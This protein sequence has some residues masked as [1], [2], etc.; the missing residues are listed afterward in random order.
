[1]NFSFRYSDHAVNIYAFADKLFNITFLI[2]LS[3]VSTAYSFKWMLEEL[4]FYFI[5]LWVAV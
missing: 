3:L 5:T 1:M 2:G 4:Q